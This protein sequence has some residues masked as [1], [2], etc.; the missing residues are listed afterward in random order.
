VDRGR[1]SS[2]S[3][4]MGKSTGW[5]LLGAAAVITI[6]LLLAGRRL[7][8]NAADAVGQHGTS[9]ADHRPASPALSATSSIAQSAGPSSKGTSVTR[10]DLL[11]FIDRR[12]R[13]V[14]ALSFAA[15]MSEPIDLE[16]LDEARQLEPDSPFVASLDLRIALERASRP[17]PAHDREAFA[18]LVESLIKRDPTNRYYQR[19]L[20]H[21]LILKREYQKLPEALESIPAEL[22]NGNLTSAFKTIYAD[23]AIHELGLPLREA[24]L[25]CPYDHFTSVTP[26][27]TAQMMAFAL[28]KK[29]LL[30]ANSPGDQSTVSPL[31]IAQLIALLQNEQK[32]RDD[33]SSLTA[34]LKAESRLVAAIS[35]MDRQSFEPFLNMSIPEYETALRNELAEAAGLESFYKELLTS[36]GDA[37]LE[38]YAADRDTHGE[39]AALRSWQEKTAAHMK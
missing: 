35:R 22:R 19:L 10:A 29:A 27:G 15:A 13:T 34:Q 32:D 20:I 23:F 28:E 8:T 39:L 25:V 14:E 11:K 7:R 16:F 30:G 5:L 6:A 2:M 9:S 24:L 17:G 21:A 12:G 18:R 36:E 1:F 37:D 26:E 31:M 38:R 33:L 3:P 4:R